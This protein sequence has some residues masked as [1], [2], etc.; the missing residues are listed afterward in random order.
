MSEEQKKIIKLDMGWARFI[1]R[2]R[3]KRPALASFLEHG[4][5]VDFSPTGV[6]LSISKKTFYWDALHERDNIDL[7]QNILKEH[8]DQE[9]PWQIV[10]NPKAQ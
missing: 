4:R 3:S 10:D 8:F 5:P 6:K 9:V 2:V 7:I 1:D